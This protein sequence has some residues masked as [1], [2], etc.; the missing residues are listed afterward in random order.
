[1]SFQTNLSFKI[2]RPG[3]GG[4]LPQGSEDIHFPVARRVNSSHKMMIDDDVE[5]GNLGPYQER[6]RIFP[7]MRSKPY[8]PLVRS[9]MLNLLFDDNCYCFVVRGLY[10]INM[11]VHVSIH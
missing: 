8:N 6:P 3:S 4:D 1:L 2:Q 10:S 9:L 7:N 11:R 5:T